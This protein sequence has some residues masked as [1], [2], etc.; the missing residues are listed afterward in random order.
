ME[1]RALVVS[2]AAL[3][4]VLAGSSARA[5]GFDTPILYSARHQGMGGTAISYV[6][7]PSAAFH[8][9]A[10]LQGVRGLALMG[11]LSLILGKV[12]ATPEPSVVSEDSNTVVAPFFLVGA[13]YRVHEWVTLGVAV[14]PVAS[15][16]AEFEYEIAGNEFIDSTNIVFAEATPVVSLSIPEDSLLPGQ[17]AI[18]AGYRASVLFFTRERG[19]PDDPRVLNLDMTG[20][21]FSGFRVGAQYR[22]VPEFGIGLAFRNKIEIT[23][24]A[25]TVTVFTQEATDAEL[26]FILP[27]KLGGGV[28]LNLEA[29][30]AAFDVEY[31]FQSQNDRVALTGNLGGMEATVPNVFEWQNGATFRVGGEYRLP[32]PVGSAIPLRLG[33]IF[34][35]KV[36]NEAYPTAF[37]TPPAPTHTLTGGAGFDAGAWEVNAAVSRRFGSTTIDEDD[38]ESGCAFCSYAGDYS[39]GMTGLYLDASVDLDI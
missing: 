19:D 23:T 12:Q 2:R 17:L 26:P 11:D 21:N 31:A 34:D 39:I 6:D 5:A 22:P 8:N 24:K 27:A 30:R 10:G 15:G 1:R 13:A 14:F 25:D 32:G 18:G 28:D 35:T 9:P 29:F 37:G 38:L 3:A 33:Y 36:T 20:T 16:G 7:D 4:L